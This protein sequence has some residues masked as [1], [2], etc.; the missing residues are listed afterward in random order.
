MFDPKLLRQLGILAAVGTEVAV[1]VV[2][3]CTG[4]YWLDGR[5]KTQPLFTLAGSLL[6]V[7][8]SGY[9]LWQIGKEFTQNK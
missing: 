3:G 7:S 1:Y 9:R 8:L 2:V 5:W 6:G 4:G